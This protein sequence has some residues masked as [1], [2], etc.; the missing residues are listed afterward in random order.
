MKLLFLLFS[1]ACSMASYSQKTDTAWWIKNLRIQTLTQHNGNKL[2]I[3]SWHANGRPMSSGVFEIRNGYTPLT[4][5]LI[6]DSNGR[7]VQEYL[8][9]EGSLINY[10]PS[11]KVQDILQSPIGDTAQR[12]TEFYTDGT[13][14]TSWFARKDTGKNGIYFYPPNYNKPISY[15]YQQETR[16]PWLYQAF[17]PTGKLYFQQ[18]Y[19]NP[20]NSILVSTWHTEAG[21]VDTTAYMAKNRSGYS[22]DKMGRRLE[23]WNN[24]HLKSE[25]NFKENRPHGRQA[26][27]HENGRPQMEKFFTEGSPSGILRT[28]Y[29]DGQLL[30]YTD[31]SVGSYGA[32]SLYFHPN[33]FIK[34]HGGIITSSYNEVGNLTNEYISLNNQNI[35]AFDGHN[36]QLTNAR[37]E[38]RFSKMRVGPWRAYNSKD[39][40]L[41]SVNYEDGL[42]SGTALFFDTAGFL[43]TKTNFVEGRFN[44]EY[45]TMNNNGRDTL[46]Y[47]HYTNG[48]RTGT[49]RIFH[50]NGLLEAVQLYEGNSYENLLKYDEQG[51]MLLSSSY[52]PIKKVRYQ[53]LYT[54]GKLTTM[55]VKHDA[56]L[57]TDTYEYYSNGG[58]KSMRLYDAEGGYTS[59]GFHENGNRQYESY[60]KK[61][62]LSH[63]KQYRWYDNG[64]LQMEGEMVNGYMEGVW[65]HYNADGSVKS[66]PYYIKGIEQ[67]MTPPN[68]NCFCNKPMPA[69][70]GSSFFNSADAYISLKSINTVM[71][72]FKLD[73]AY[74]YAFVRC[75][76]CYPTPIIAVR[77]Q[78]LW[79][80]NDGMY[81]NLTPCLHGSNKSLLHIY[82]ASLHT[83]KG[84]YSD[85]EN[86][87][88]LLAPIT[89]AQLFERAIAVYDRGNGNHIQYQQALEDLSGDSLML[90]RL[91]KKQYGL[92]LEARS[93]D[94]EK[95]NEAIQQALDKYNETNHKDIPF[96]RHFAAMLVKA[97]LPY[98]PTEAKILAKDATN[99]Q[100]AT[101]IFRK[102]FAPEEP[103]YL[104]RE[105]FGSLQVTLDS[106]TVA[107]TIPATFIASYDTVAKKKVMTEGKPVA[108]PFMVSFR[109]AY[110]GSYPTDN[111]NIPNADALG[112]CAKPFTVGSTNA[113]I[114]PHHFQY[115]LGKTS[116]D[117]QL[118]N[119]FNYPAHY[120]NLRMVGDSTDRHLEAELDKYIQQFMGVMIQ[121]GTMH[122]PGL[123]EPVTITETIIDA[124]EING[125]IKM[126]Q[127]ELAITEAA[128]AKALTAAGFRVF[129]RQ[130][131]WDVHEEPM[132]IL[133]FQ[134][135]K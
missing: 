22:Y 75:H 87:D 106:G 21:T 46:Q 101:N 15:M 108:A 29:E 68:D 91:L 67:V 18:H 11:G 12:Y 57:G 31:Y 50:R 128:L 88:E 93:L 102:F 118:F 39:Q 49:W 66:R 33:G 99:R 25:E 104:E 98:F 24:G 13:I 60:V 43:H 4:N 64:Q 74:R 83:V 8:A 63:G 90:Y 116:E 122:L 36:T 45:L 129:Y 35:H 92:A 38:G 54:N 58:V 34:T 79:I 133:Y 84:S 121:Q 71:Q 65:T 16:A 81:L 97:I 119:A 135:R 86:D 70:A 112:Y 28:W 89:L 124:N 73:T 77:E 56:F 123:T 10:L 61:G 3:R 2:S 94:E 27:W 127:S 114:M 72:R 62:N 59:K 117:D 82:E 100:A 131:G 105:L 19:T 53:Y 110:Y 125:C 130:D 30:Y 7:K 23:W 80:D 76:N 47:G 14:K 55:H 134:L 69:I 32:S 17:Y 44:G 126:P 6:L 109:K 52:D 95:E 96:N 113:W 115:L 85:Y 1:M 132:V 26:S 20:P 40:L 78:K 51:N 42:L 5:I 41:Y 48:R 120:K 37:Y 111:L 9:G 103:E 107:L